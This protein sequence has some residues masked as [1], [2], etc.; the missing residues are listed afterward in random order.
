MTTQ[1]GEGWIAR[2]MGERDDT[3]AAKQR[4]LDAFLA[5]VERSALRMAEFAVSDREEALDIVQDVMFAFARR[6][7]R[8]PVEQWK[9]L[10]YRCLEN[11]IRD[12]YRRQGVRSR[13][14]AWLDRPDEPPMAQRFEDHGT[15][16]P[17]ER[18]R[19]DDFGE[20]LGAALSALPH[21][22]RQAFLLRSWEGLSVAEAATAMGCGQGSVKTHLSR[23]MKQLRERLAEFEDG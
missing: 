18:R 16:T 20:A 17:V 4:E 12:W 5:E 21:R 11:R 9:P 15:P 23:A 7:V 14:M 19:L 6:Y 1:T 10:F 2:G 8:K 3:T 22:Q 13:W